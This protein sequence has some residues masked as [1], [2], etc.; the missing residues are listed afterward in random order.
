NSK[1]ESLARVEKITGKAPVFYRADCADINSLRKIFAAH[2][3]ITSVIHFAGYKAVG[4]SVQKPLLYYRNNIDS[5]LA[6]LEVMKEYGVKNL[7]FSSSATVYGM[8]KKCPLNESSPTSALNPYGNTKKMIE[9]ILTDAY[10][11][12]SSLNIALLRYFNPVGAHESGLIG[13]DPKGIPNNLMPYICGVAV[14][15]YPKLNIF[16]SDYPTPDGTCIRDYIH[17]VDLAKGHLAALEKL[18]R[19][20]GL[21]VYNLG[22]GKGSSVKEIVAAFQKSTG[23]TLPHEYVGR[24]NGDA[25]SC[26]AS[27]AKAKKELGWKAEKTL[28]EM[29]KSH[30]EWQRK[31]PEGYL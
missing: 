23:I 28:E 12:D 9:E 13:E 6:L 15:K 30:Y 1:K 2:T 14:G 25:P 26:Y 18:N 5:S 11:A 22:T 21:V 16:G 8:P 24:R 19:K 3:D 10:K 20:P 17:V 31:N 27:T 29:C 4:E 7:V